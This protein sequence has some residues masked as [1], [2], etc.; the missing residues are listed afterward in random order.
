MNRLA[1][2]IVCASIGV[3][4]ATASAGFTANY[5]GYG[6]FESHM[7]GYSTALSWDSAASVTMFN[8]KLA[9]HKWTLN[10]ETT[11]TWCA[12]LY[13]GVTAGN[14]YYFDTVALEQAPQTPPAPG[15]MGVGR[16][17]VLRDAMSRFLQ[18]DGRVAS[19]LGSAT[20][21]T[22]ALCALSWE[23]IHENFNTQDAETVRS[24]IDL[25]KGAFRTVL[26]GESAAIFAAMV[27]NI[28]NGG[29]RDVAAEGWTSPTAQDQ[30]RMVPTPGSLAIL[31]LA[32]IAALRRRR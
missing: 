11:Y 3:A 15:P 5:V 27:S 21:A 24:R 20:A 31:G 14:N 18:S 28:G 23:I 22:A 32:G 6:L 25:S 19:G 1:K 26:S 12:Q 10:G 8:L 17:T 13:Q 2:G 4:S 7:V 30:F 29:Y 9:E 16:A